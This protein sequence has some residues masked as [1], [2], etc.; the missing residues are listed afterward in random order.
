MWV[1]KLSTLEV[2][3]PCGKVADDFGVFTFVLEAIQRSDRAP[4]GFG[5]AQ[6]G[7]AGD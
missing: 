6:F 2:G 7:I 4:S 1:Y 3:R 5:S